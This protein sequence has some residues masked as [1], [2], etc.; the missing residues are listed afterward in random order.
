MIGDNMKDKSNKN[1]IIILTVLLVAIL[2]VLVIGATFAYFSVNLK[3]VKNLENVQ[4][5]ANTVVVEYSSTN[6]IFYENVIPGRPEWN[7]GEKATNKLTFMVTTPTDATY[8][9]P[10]DVYLDITKNTFITDNVV[11]YLQPITCDRSDKTGSLKGELVTDNTLNYGDYDGTNVVL[12]V[13]PAGF[14][15]KLKVYGGSV[16]G[17][18]GCQDKWNFEIWLNELGV[19]QNEDQAKTLE[20]KIDIETGLPYPVDFMNN[21]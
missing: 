5:K 20:A 18:L 13:I 6:S 17:S 10:Y 3:Y 2:F 21:Y 7:D 1:S 4:V 9:V 12:G 15:G 19:V 8:K 11:F 16:V 14:T